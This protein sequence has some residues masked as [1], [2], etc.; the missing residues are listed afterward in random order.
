[1]NFILIWQAPI[2]FFQKWWLSLPSIVII[3]L[4]VRVLRLTKMH[5]YLN[6]PPCIICTPCII[7]FRHGTSGIF[8]LWA[9]RKYRP[10]LLCVPNVHNEEYVPLKQNRCIFLYIL[11]WNIFSDLYVACGQQQNENYMVLIDEYLGSQQ[12]YFLHLRIKFL[13]YV[14]SSNTNNWFNVL[15]AAR[16]QLQYLEHCSLSSHN[17]FHF[18]STQQYLGPFNKPTSPKVFNY[19][20]FAAYCFTHNSAVTQKRFYWNLMDLG[21]LLEVKIHVFFYFFNF[22][23]HL[24]LNEWDEDELT[25]LIFNISRDLFAL[26]LDTPVM[27]VYFTVR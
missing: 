14:I 13:H 20:T 2:V 8:G 25:S 16:G 10:I 12:I 9:F 4:Q 22:H 19:Y 21:P 17:L 18:C 6:V 23:I 24:F 7:W 1:M 15:T 27:A 26:L 3:K 11:V 5:D